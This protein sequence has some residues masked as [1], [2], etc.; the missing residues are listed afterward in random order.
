MLKFTA[1]LFAFATTSALGW[2]LFGPI[3]ILYAAG[4]ILFTWLADGL[5][6]LLDPKTF[7]PDKP[8]PGTH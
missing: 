7:A 4:F 1:F 3:G 6:A 8:P 5:T 2:F